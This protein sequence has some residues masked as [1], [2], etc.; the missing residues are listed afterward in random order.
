MRDDRFGRNPIVIT[1]KIF[2]NPT[3]EEKIL[4]SIHREI[5]IGA[6]FA[7]WFPVRCDAKRAGI[8]DDVFVDMFAMIGR[9][10]LPMR[11]LECS[12]A[13]H[14]QTDAIGHAAPDLVLA[15]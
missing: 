13:E 3:D 8:F 9:E 5:Q 11:P 4:G 1:R 15:A 2:Q 12:K 14:L 7:S 10:P 6:M